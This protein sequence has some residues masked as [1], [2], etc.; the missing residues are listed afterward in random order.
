M[1]S[2][3]LKSISTSMP[4]G[5]FSDNLLWFDTALTPATVLA[6]GARWSLPDLKAADEATR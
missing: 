4:N 1:F 3:L 6:R 2:K 5:W